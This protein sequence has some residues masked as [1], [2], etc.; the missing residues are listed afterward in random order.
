MAANTLA[1]ARLELNDCNKHVDAT[2][3][4]A[5]IAP[6][7]AGHAPGITEH[8]AE[9]LLHNNSCPYISAML[10]D[11]GVISS[12]AATPKDSWL[13]GLCNADALPAV[14]WQPVAVPLQ[15]DIFVLD[16]LY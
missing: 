15:R 8:I 6:R 3:R 16:S 12:K 11:D 1:A 4:L 10:G 9:K 7:L 13:Q 2:H 5:V 14:C